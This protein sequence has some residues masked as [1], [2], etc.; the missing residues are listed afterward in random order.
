[1][2]KLAY[3]FYCS[4]NF[5]SMVDSLR[6]LRETGFTAI[7]GYGGL[8]DDIRA[9]KAALD[10]AGMSMT[11]S[12]IGLDMV[13]S[14][15]SGMVDTVKALGIE[16]AF[17]P[18]LQV[19]DRPTT[20]QG[21]RDMGAR[22]WAAGA[23]L[24]AAGVPYGWHN[25]DFELVPLEGG[26]PLDFMIEGAPNLPL[27]LDLGWVVR[28]GEDPVAWINKYGSR[29]I[30]AHIKD[31]AAPGENADEDGWADVGQ[32]TLDWPAI[33]A[34]LQAAGCTRYV[35]EHDNP[36]DHARFARRSFDAVSKF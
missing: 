1:M 5:P 4:R 12:H 31:V 8:F 23:K 2:I 34:A 15:P 26:T 18:H 29:I 11:S 22:A 17:V 10:E 35:T 16:A 25:H 28:A 30:A 36:A 13:E 24:R 7:E 9:L 3:Q 20:A 21:W 19:A 6:M 33:H 32:G 27:E 14:D